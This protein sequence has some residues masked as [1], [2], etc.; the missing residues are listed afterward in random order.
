MRHDF[1]NF[2]F[3]SRI[4]L[5]QGLGQAVG[6]GAVVECPDDERPRSYTREFAP[7]GE[8]GDRLSDLFGE[9]VRP[10]DLD[11]VGYSPGFGLPRKVAVDPVGPARTRVS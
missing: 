8:R 9:G 7:L 10:V 5:T 3:Q 1:R 2:Y 11:A 6:N 4:G